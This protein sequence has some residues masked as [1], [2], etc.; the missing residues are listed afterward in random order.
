MEGEVPPTP[1]PGHF[2]KQSQSSLHGCYV[3]EQIHTRKGKLSNCLKLL[4]TAPLTAPNPPGKTQIMLL[5]SE[6]LALGEAFL[7]I[8]F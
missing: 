1:H 8:A 5:P 7:S 3:G 4:F 2:K 6:I